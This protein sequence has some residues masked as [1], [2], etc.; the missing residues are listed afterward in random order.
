MKNNKL[1]V[2]FSVVVITFASIFAFTTSVHAE[3]YYHY[4]NWNLGAD[5]NDYL[6]GINGYVDSAGLIEGIPG[7]EYIIFAGSYAGYTGYHYAYLY[8]VETAGDP[9]MHPDNPDAPGPIATRTF[10]LVSSH[11]LG[12]F[13]SGH[14]NAFYVDDTGI[15]YG[16]SKG[17]SG[18][19][20]PG[21][22]GIFHWD[23][24]WNP[25]GE[26][27]P[28]F[29]GNAQTLARYSVTGDWWVGDSNRNIYKWDGT[30][31]TYQ[32]TH[33]NLTGGH[34]DGMEIIGDSLFI[35]DMTSD[36]IIQYRLDADGNVIDPPDTPYNTF[37]YSNPAP[38]EGMGFGPNGH[39]W[40]AGWSS[41]TV[42]EIG[43]GALQQELE[44]EIPVDIKPTSCRN[45]LNVKKKGVL[46]VAILGTDDF[47]VTQVDLS[48]VQLAGVVPVR[49]SFEDV[50]TP[51]EPYTGKIDAFDCT[52][53]GP[54]GYLDLTLKFDARTIIEALGDVENGDVLLLHLTGNLLAEFG[55]RKIKGEDVVVILNK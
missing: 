21:W 28:V 41:H 52:T 39:I 9:N 3:D 37:S 8:R 26:V 45:P 20:G 12:Y 53:D 47:D 14:E 54:D 4:G 22:G 16:A 35:S 51:F 44:I 10:S 17:W 40:V 1:F 25:L 49:S 50:A 13:R 11:Y 5:G 55:G 19:A 7:A 2:L 18:P 31:W 46:S 36:V 15:Y 24:N 48:T 33:P 34:H 30:S 23:F 27:V 42:Y 6:T 43:G 38:V 32:F 29:P